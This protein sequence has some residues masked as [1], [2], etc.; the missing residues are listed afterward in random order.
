MT[1]EFLSLLPFDVTPSPTRGDARVNRVYTRSPTPVYSLRTILYTE[2]GWFTDRREEDGV[3][4]NFHFWPI[5]RIGSKEKE[6]VEIFEATRIVERKYIIWKI[7]LAMKFFSKKIKFNKEFSFF[8]PPS[9]F[10]QRTRLKFQLNPNT[11]N[12]NR[13]TKRYDALLYVSHL[14]WNGYIHLLKTR[15]GYERLQ[16]KG[17]KKNKKSFESN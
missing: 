14:S 4:Y 9:F 8:F 10:L 6:R 13:E 2:S 16:K 1:G 7:S 17:L 3:A 12:N 15:Y 5:E 11:G